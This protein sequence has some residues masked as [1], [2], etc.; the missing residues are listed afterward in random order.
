MVLLIDNYDSFTFNVYQILL[1]LNCEVMVKRNDE[2]T[3]GE[4]EKLNPE[5]IIISPGPSRPENAGISN[6]IIESFKEKIP[7]LGICLGHECIGYVFGANIIH[8]GKIYHGKTSEITH[9]G[10]G[11]F[12]G[13]RNGFLATRY[14]S[15]V[16]DKSNVPDDLEITAQSEDGEIMG[17][18]HKQYKIEGVQF[19]PESIATEFGEQ[20]IKNFLTESAKVHS[21]TSSIQK[22]KSGSDLSVEE[23][24]EV[25]E[26]ISNGK[27]A[28]TQ[29]AAILTAL[30]IKGESVSEITGF[31]KFMRE[32]VK[33]I[34][35]PDDKIIIDTCGTGGDTSGT[36]NIS[37]IAAF[38]TA[39]AG[40]Y[41]AKHGNRS[42]TSKCGSADIL[43][44]L[45]V[46]IMIDQ[47]KVSESLKKIG[48]AFLFA[49]L[50]HDSVKNAV[51]VRRDIAIRTLF[52]ILG[53]LV[54]PAN[55]DRQLIGVYEKGMVD[56]L[57]KTLINLNVKRALVVH[58]SDGLDEITT[59]GYSH[60]AEVN[61]GWVKS[62]EFDP[63]NF[64]FRYA[65]PDELL[66]GDIKTNKMI[67][68]SVLKGEKGFKHDIVLLNAAA[69]IYLADDKL[70]LEESIIKAEK[71]IE[72]GAAFEKLNE[73]IKFT[74]N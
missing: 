45:G 17:V 73:L 44:A 19:H 47:K 41:V 62:Y 43:E 54:N 8:A 72:S 12:K 65:P 57:A 48:I 58:G 27:A 24:M 42:V 39:G 37:T 74:N 23:A 25:M 64:G 59:T 55:S 36:F 49:P 70:S 16:I 22:I 67:A 1:K 21:I 31:A 15:L 26:E 56:K 20:L 9:D 53:P 10:K 52:N 68:L 50:L 63:R 4:I 7:I 13:I 33:K 14:H 11:V 60:F 46:N 69:A 6:S 38:V 3:I 40:Y 61:N 35:R 71:S 2:I 32:K 29:I 51:P 5:R 30:A 28:P 18:R 66:G 34:E